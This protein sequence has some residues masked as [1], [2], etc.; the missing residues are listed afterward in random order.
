MI[1]ISKTIEK[2]TVELMR[3]KQI[4]EKI[5]EMIKDEIEDS[6]LKFVLCKDLL[7]TIIT[8]HNY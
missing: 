1:S 6:V 4:I 3:D 2:S 8:L 5:M 7:K